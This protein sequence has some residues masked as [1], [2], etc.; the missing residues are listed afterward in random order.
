MKAKKG[1][2]FVG[3]ARVENSSVIKQHQTIDTEA[4]FAASKNE[5]YYQKKI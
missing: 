3:K 2:L 5:R 4:S 1:R